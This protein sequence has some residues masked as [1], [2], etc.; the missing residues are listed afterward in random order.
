MNWPTPPNIINPST[1]TDWPK[2]VVPHE[3]HVVRKKADGAPY[4]VSVIDFEDFHVDRLTGEVT[5]MVKDEEDESRAT[6]ELKAE[7][8]VA[9]EDAAP[10]SIAISADDGEG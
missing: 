6:A 1:S 9:D 10:V 8:P 7:E 3:S 5:V 2:W 4:H